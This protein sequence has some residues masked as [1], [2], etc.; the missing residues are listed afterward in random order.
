MDNGE[1]YTMVAGVACRISNGIDYDALLREA[2]RVA[3]RLDTDPENDNFDDIYNRI[4]E[5]MD[6]Y[7]HSPESDDLFDVVDR[8]DVDS[9]AG[10]KFC[11]TLMTRLAS[12]VADV[13]PLEERKR[14]CTN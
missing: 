2:L 12:C 13:I 14:K 7:V 9:G 8:G 10:C 11:S 4:Y 3:L 6:A 1:Q 5:L